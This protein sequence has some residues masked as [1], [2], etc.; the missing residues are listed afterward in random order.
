MEEQFDIQGY[1]A[2]NVEKL[3]RDGWLAAVHLVVIGIVDVSDF[4]GI[5]VAAVRAFPDMV[6]V[7]EALLLV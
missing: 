3:V 6:V 4:D 5:F 1:L 2:K 7:V